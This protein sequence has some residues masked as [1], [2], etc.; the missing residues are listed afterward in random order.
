MSQKQAKH[1]PLCD[2]PV[3]DS[4]Y[5]RH[6]LILEDEGTETHNQR[7]EVRLCPNCWESFQTELATR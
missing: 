2:E 4:P 7:K 1:C 6:R 3:A 5:P